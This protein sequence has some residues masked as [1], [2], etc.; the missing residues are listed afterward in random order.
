MAVFLAAIVFA[1]ASVPAVLAQKGEMRLTG[2]KEAI[3]IYWQAQMK[4]DNQDDPGTLFDQAV[5]KDPNFAYGYLFA[6]QT[7]RDFQL[8]LEKAVALVDKVSPG[9]RE[10]ILAVQAANNGDQAGAMQHW[11]QLAKLY[12]NDKRVQSQVGFFYRGSGDEATANKYFN[13]AA[14]IDGKWAPAYNNLGYSNVALGRWSDAEKAFKTYVSLIPNNP[15]PYD[16]YG[17]MLM[18]SGKY[19]ESIKQY[20]MALAKDKTFYNSYRGVGDNYA[21]KGDFDKAR[22]QYKQMY[23]VSAGNPGFRDTALIAMLDSWLYQGHI[24]EA[25]KVN[26]DRIA[27]FQKQGDPQSLFFAHSFAAFIATEGGDYDAAAKHL[28]MATEVMKDPALPA[29]LEAGRKFNAAAARAR[30]AIARGDVAGAQSDLDW[31]GTAARNPNQQFNYNFLR[32]YAEIKQGHF[33]KASEFLAKANPQDSMTW[34]YQA[35]ALEGAGDKA[36]AAKLYKKIVDWNQLDQPNYAIVR[37]R[38]VAKLGK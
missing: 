29:G 38:A 25:L 24:A 14:R 16:S 26:D 20:S 32:G 1:F 23:D 18:N 30:L 36:G 21:Y 10:W 13:E 7:N 27:E 4:A 2:S 28:S 33:A 34:Y 5:Q 17:E 11:L 22:A 35:I 8:N 19:D 3:A 37:P 31:L 6:G 12:P 15:N 9:E